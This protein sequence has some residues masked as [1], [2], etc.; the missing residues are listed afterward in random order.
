MSAVL[1]DNYCLR[2]LSPMVGGDTNLPRAVGNAV[3]SLTPSMNLKRT[4]K[5]LIKI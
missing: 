5:N 3:T 4:N 1:S 2:W